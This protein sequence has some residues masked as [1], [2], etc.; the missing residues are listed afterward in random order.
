MWMGILYAVAD[1]VIGSEARQS[2]RDRGVGSG[3]GLPRRCAPR[4]DTKRET[5]AMTKRGTLAMTKQGVIRGDA[6]DGVIASAAR[7]S[8]RG[9][10]VGSGTGLPRR[11]APRNDRKRETLA[12]TT[13]G[14]LAMTKQG[15]IRG[16]A[17]DVVIASAARQSRRGR[18]VGSGT[19]LPRRCAPRNDRKRNARND[20]KR[21]TL[22]MT[23][24]GTLAMTKQGVIRGDASDVVIA[25]AARQ[26][27]SR[28][29][30][31]EGVPPMVLK[32]TKIG[33][34]MVILP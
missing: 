9:R 11:C 14:T 29:A 32:L 1:A 5:L 16:D 27:R 7:Q 25:S 6:S 26:S 3:T 13:R 31:G 24:R 23:K 21:E 19:G 17:S 30:R 8:R 15:V 18:G 28:R 33:V 34:F 10:G 2:R 12:M 22:A 4:N 20:R